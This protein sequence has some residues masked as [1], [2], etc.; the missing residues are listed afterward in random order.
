MNS[1]KEIIQI[2]EYR[3]KLLDR[4]IVSHIMEL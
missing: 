4:M 3:K 1:L 2:S